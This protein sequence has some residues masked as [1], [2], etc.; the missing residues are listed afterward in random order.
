MHAAGQSALADRHEVHI[1]AEMAGDRAEP[2][3]VTAAMV[4]HVV[5]DAR[6]DPD[7]PRP[8]RLMRRV[9]PTGPGYQSCVTGSGA[10]LIELA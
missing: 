9:T 7:Y 6:H 2:M 1:G 5:A 3:L 4:V 10:D 8:V